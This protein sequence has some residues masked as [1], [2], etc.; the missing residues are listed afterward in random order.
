MVYA[1]IIKNN[2]DNIIRVQFILLFIS[3]NELLNYENKT[4]R[5]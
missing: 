3:Q 4:T 5:Y 2:N 1:G